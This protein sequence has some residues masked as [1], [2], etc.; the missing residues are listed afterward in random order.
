MQMTKMA[1]F[2][3]FTGFHNPPN[4]IKL[5]SQLSTVSVVWNLSCQLT[6]CSFTSSALSKSVC[7]TACH[8]ALLTV[9]SVP[10]ALPRHTNKTGWIRP[11]SAESWNVG[12]T[13]ERMCPL[14]ET[15]GRF[16]N[17]WLSGPKN[18]L[19]LHLFYWSRAFIT[20]VPGRSSGSVLWP[21]RAYLNRLTTVD[22]CKDASVIHSNNSNTVTY[23]FFRWSHR[24]S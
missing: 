12:C 17:K 20:N 13:T 15:S 2:S 5:Q 14:S 8:S 1:D 22:N 7:S 9:Y 11:G 23:L 24:R 19:S 16:T 6:S 4:P 18:A 21:I 3:L 10:P